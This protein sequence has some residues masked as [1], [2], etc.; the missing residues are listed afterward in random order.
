MRLIRLMGALAALTLA[1]PALAQSA[2]P[3]MAS[4]PDGTVSV[5]VTIDGD[6]RAA[7]A[8]SRKGKAIL[9]PSKLGFLFTDVVKLDRRIEVTGQEL[10]DFD[11]TWTQPWGEWT[12]IRNH[13]RELK[14]DFRETTALAR[15][16]TV[17]FRLYNDGVGFRYEFP[18]QPNMRHANIAEELT[19]FAFASDGTA[20]WKPAFLWNREE[21]LYNK[22][23]LS[24]VANA[25]T[26]ITIRLADG[27]HVA[28][29]EAA[30]VDYSGMAVARTEGNTLRA[31]LHPGAGEAKVRKHGA[32]NSPW[33]TLIIADVAGCLD[34]NASVKA[35]RFV[36]FCDCFNIPLLV[37]E[38]VPGF[39]P[40]TDQEW[41]GIIK[42]GAKLLYAF[43][44]A[45]ARP[46]LQPRWRV[47]RLT[48][49]NLAQSIL[50]GFRPALRNLR[51]GFPSS[52]LQDQS[53]ICL[54]GAAPWCP[55]HRQWHSCLRQ[56]ASTILVI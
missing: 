19:E 52:L 40:G 37:F 8:V 55:K 51:Q 47:V 54:Q 3:V 22:T 50:L 14:V 15:V 13:Y 56:A 38:D 26:P 1:A 49:V 30:L 16:F 2:A 20:W 5:A 21:Y 28:L 12:T 18:D 7:Y 43:S 35:A 42:H 44:E 45:T 24:A 53:L 48:V 6:G 36:R 39:L 23:A 11:E 10:R 25:D 4:S 34:I 29:H 9:A 41:H 31:A 32:W 33:R 46:S 17:T 27:T